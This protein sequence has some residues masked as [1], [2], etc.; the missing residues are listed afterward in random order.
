MGKEEEPD[1]EITVCQAVSKLHLLISDQMELH[2]SGLRNL[3]YHTCPDKVTMFPSDVKN[4][5]KCHF[6]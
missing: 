1:H 6:K 2:N 4:V 3:T 5:V